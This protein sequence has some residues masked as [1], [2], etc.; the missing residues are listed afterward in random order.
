[1]T[2]HGSRYQKT[3]PWK[4]TIFPETQQEFALDYPLKAPVFEHELISTLDSRVFS[5]A[6]K[7]DIYLFV[8]ESLREDYI[9]SENAPFIHRFKQENLS[10]PL[11]LSNANA[12][13]ISW[14]SLFHSKYPIYWGQTPWSVQKEGSL[15]LR[16]L[17]KMGY[18]IHVLCSAR[19][20]FFNM[21]KV[22]FGEHGQL[23][24]SLYTF[25][26]DL[27][28]L[29]CVRDQKVMDRLLQMKEESAGSRLFIVFLDSTHHDYSWPEDKKCLFHPFEEKI[30]YIKS[31]FLKGSLEGVQNRYRNALHFVDSLF[32][33][34]FVSLEES[35]SSK[36]SVVVIT[37]DH[38]EEFYE[39]GNLF[40]ASGLT[41]PQ[42]HVP[43]Y[44][45]FG[46]HQE[47]HN[48]AGCAMT[49]HMDIFPSL[50]H[51]LIGEDLLGDVLQ[52]QSIFNTHR[53]PFVVT[54]RFSMSR[55][56]SEFFIHNGR[57]KV[58]ASFTD[59]NDIFQSKGLK[60]LARKSLSDELLP[61]DIPTVKEEFK[62]AFERL[63]PEV[64]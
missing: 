55:P 56:P 38:G 39:G 30:N 51:Y 58:L 42:T 62:E 59:E 17:K 5:L 57:S 27:S 31:A 61:H 18:R 60:I 10:F 49:C 23:A 44:Y 2:A 13:H 63:F 54:G 28:L 29:P 9:T 8:I 32:E 3:L 20:P 24:D 21:N 25:D 52:G 43:L 53:W 47:L 64:K 45:K 26:D 35:V 14:F 22:L 36:E 6:R 46:N 1:V 37:A 50:F 4:T 33:K 15:P 34:F 12:T 11:A 19:L 7:P 48:E 41:H 16:L 40:H